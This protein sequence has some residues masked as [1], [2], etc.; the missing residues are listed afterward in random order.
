MAS[1]IGP[2][3]HATPGRGRSQPAPS[4]GSWAP[5]TTRSIQAGTDESTTSVSGAGSSN[6]PPCCGRIR[7][8]P[9]PA[10]TTPGI[11]IAADIKEVV[12]ASESF[13]VLPKQMTRIVARAMTMGVK[14]S[15]E[16]IRQKI[17]PMIKGGPTRWTQRGLIVSYAKPT[18]LRAQVGFN[19]GEGRFTDTEYTPKAGGIPSG[20]Y[21][22]INARGGDRRAKSI[23]RQLRLTGVIPNDAFLVPN[24]NLAE[25]DRYGNL[26]G[27]TW[28][29]IG[30]RI[31]GLSTS[32]STQNAPKGQGSRGRT[33]RK[34]RQD[35]YFVMRYSGGYPAGP[36]ELGA[37]PAFIA[38][39]V[40][41][42]RG[43]KR[44]FEIA[45]FITDQPNYERKWP[46]QPIAFREFERVFKIEFTN[47]IR[48][49][50]AYRKR[51]GI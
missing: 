43:K 21:M 23:E 14:S 33:A 20:R 26:P 29:K 31:R 10:V 38:R 47:G 36:K 41:L 2:R 37:T 50:I 12:A 39:R 30:S 28:T 19:Y 45:L 8:V 13:G 16:E 46:I 1:A 27:T 9:Y 34:R 18:D 15:R 40:G 35:D 49:S 22:G 24:P 4:G 6:R 25:I 42:R 5:L 3:A 7:S 48:S 17:F 32:G 44:G 11:S 51:H